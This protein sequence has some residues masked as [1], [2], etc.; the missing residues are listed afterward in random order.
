MLNWYDNSSLTTL[1]DYLEFL[2]VFFIAE[3]FISQLGFGRVYGRYL[4]AR[5]SRLQLTIHRLMVG[6]RDKIEL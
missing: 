5:L 4:V 6:L 3:M 1:C 2:L